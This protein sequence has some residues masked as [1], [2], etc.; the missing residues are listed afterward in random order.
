MKF[1]VLVTMIFSFVFGSVDL[2]TATEKELVSLKYI[3]S[4]KANS[5]I[6]FRKAHCFKNVDEIV[7]VKGIGKKFLDENRANLTAS[8]CKQ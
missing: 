6:A 8:E 2:N 1:L 7:N 4:Q 3:G 5:I